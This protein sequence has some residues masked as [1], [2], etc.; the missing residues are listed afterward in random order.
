[1]KD[2]LIQLS[3]QPCE[4]VKEG[5]ESFVLYMKKL[6]TGTS[7]VGVLYYRE[8]SC[9]TRTRIQVCFPPAPFPTPSMILLLDYF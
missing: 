6:R 1:M 8:L 4:L 7:W 2:I 5:C 9:G 3:Y